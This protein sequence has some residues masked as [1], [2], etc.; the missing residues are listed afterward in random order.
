M[1]A[2]N[3]FMSSYWKKKHEKR[4]AAIKR[5][6]REIRIDELLT[7]TQAAECIGCSR[8]RFLHCIGKYE[9]PHLRVYKHVFVQRSVVDAIA[10]IDGFKSFA[11]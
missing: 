5:A 7:P 2:A 4:R 10:R 3:E 11:E 6:I 1:N 9:I 8:S